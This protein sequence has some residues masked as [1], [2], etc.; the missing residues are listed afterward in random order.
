MTINRS[1]KIPGTNGQMPIKSGFYEVQGLPDGKSSP[2]DIELS[3]LGKHRVKT[4]PVRH[5]LDRIFREEWA[6][7]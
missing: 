5:F 6:Q 1:I 7:T 2:N 4:L 3:L